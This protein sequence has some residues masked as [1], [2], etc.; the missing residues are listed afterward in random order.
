MTSEQGM[1]LQGTMGLEIL[2][3]CPAEQR[4]QLHAIFVPIGGGG[5]AAGIAAL[6]KAVDPSILVIGVEPTGGRR[7]R[8]V[9]PILQILIAHAMFMARDPGYWHGITGPHIVLRAPCGPEAQTLRRWS[10]VCI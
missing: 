9:L 6:V 8:F 3:H 7:H 4:A 1:R 5:M 2:R 10:A